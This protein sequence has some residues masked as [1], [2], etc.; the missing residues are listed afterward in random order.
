[1]VKERA[2]DFVKL[3]A[4]NNSEAVVYMISNPGFPNLFL[5]NKS[6]LEIKEEDIA[7]REIYEKL[8]KEGIKNIRYIRGDK[9]L[10]TDG[11]TTVD[12]VHFTDLGF[13][14]FAKNLLRYIK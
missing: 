4:T 14:R 7:W 12:G 6:R 9:L 8:R 5:D 3:I 11:E 10:G 13:M 1:M 2:Y